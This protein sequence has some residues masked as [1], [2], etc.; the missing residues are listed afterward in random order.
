MTVEEIEI[1]VTAKIEDALKE[2]KKIVPA[3]RQSVKQ[4]QEAFS[5][6][7]TKTVQNKFGQAVQFMKKKIQDLRKNN[8]SNE[9]T[10]K[11]NN[12]DA[13]KQ[14][15][16]VQKQIYS[17][18]EKINARQ[19][20]LNAITPRLDKITEK[21][22][23]DV[24][25]DGL[26]SDNPAVQ[27]TINSSLSSNKEYNSLLAQEE[28]ITQEIAMYN[29]KLNEA[30]NKISQLKQ[31]VS[32]TATTQNKLSSFFNAFKGKIDQAKNS[33]TNMKNTFK[34]M[35]NI[36]QNVTNNIKNMGTGVKNGLRH[37]LR[38]AM[39]LF[40]LRGIYSI[41]SNCAS[42]WLNSQS[43]GAKQLS[44]NIDYMKYAMR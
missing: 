9:I 19:M 32:Q 28:K 20:K 7:D 16:Q 14:I 1:I 41:L 11:V 10:I 21:T 26:S 12:K 13:Q 34:G 18:Q 25:P 33:M 29:N 3:I 5:S 37:V 17:L 44:A 39:A 4:A 42:T 40:S 24:T 43:A 38:Y 31:E 15:S 23:K 35:P 30:K 2:F 8:K 22:I 6:I 36:T 27:K